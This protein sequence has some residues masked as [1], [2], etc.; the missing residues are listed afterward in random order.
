MN[1]S[2]VSGVT[3]LDPYPFEEFAPTLSQCYAIV[4]AGYL[5]AKTQLLS[6]SDIRGVNAF[7]NYF[8]MPAIICVS[9]SDAN[10]GDFNWELL[11]GLV[12]GKALVFVLV[13]SLTYCISGNIGI[14][15]LLAI[16]CVHSNDLPVGN[17]L[18]SSLYG[19]YRPHMIKYLFL[20]PALTFAIFL[21]IGN[22]MVAVNR[23]RKPPV[24]PFPSTSF[25]SP[26]NLEKSSLVR[27]FVTTFSG[28]L[29]SPVVIA[30]F[31]GLIM[32]VFF[33]GNVP[34]V[35]HKP[36][37]VVAATI[38]GLALSLLGFSFVRKER[39]FLSSGIILAVVLVAVKMLLT[40]LLM[41]VT[42]KILTPKLKE[43]KVLTDFSLLYGIIS[44]ATIVFQIGQEYRKL[45]PAMSVA[46]ILSSLLCFPLSYL[47][48]RFTIA[49]VNK[50]SYYIPH[51][52]NSLFFI[53]SCSV[54]CD[55]FVWISIAWKKKWCK[56]PFCYV[57]H[58]AF[59]QMLTSCG[60]I[61]W[62]LSS[63]ESWALY[64]QMALYYGGE[65]SGYLWSGTMAVIVTLSN[66]YPELAG[67]GYPILSFTAFF[68]SALITCVMCSL[69]PYNDVQ[70][71]YIV[72]RARTNFAFL[73]LIVTSVLLIVC[74]VLISLCLL[75]HFKNSFRKKSICS[76]RIFCLEN[77]P[78]E[79][80]ICKSAKRSSLENIKDVFTRKKEGELYSKENRS[81]YIK[82]GEEDMENEWTFK[83]Y[84][85]ILLIWLTMTLK[86][87]ANI[88]KL[89]HSQA[90]EIMVP[91]EFLQSSLFVGQGIFIFLTFGIDLRTVGISIVKKW[92]NFRYGKENVLLEASLHDA[93]SE[94]KLFCK[95]FYA[96]Y[97]KHCVRDL[98]KD[99]KWKSAV[100]RKCFWG[101]QL[102]D[103]LIEERICQDD[104]EA[105]DYGQKLLLGGVIRHVT[106]TR[107]FYDA[108]YLYKFVGDTQQTK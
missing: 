87:I 4:L 36:I 43:F 68:L 38:P 29:K 21:P 78:N 76:D 75:I 26:N 19:Y 90:L 28:A 20:M 79:E 74:F 100:Y 88:F 52:Q 47:V 18:V 96:F 8:A 10:F 40:P 45:L 14:A 49:P 34:K 46:L 70:K 97:F 5:A 17:P 98:A 12:V 50:L 101:H 105:E 33:R 62:C 35:L 66:K 23:L 61:M 7:A 41:H 1:I 77:D 25:N 65:I 104:A 37:H 64:C 99:R 39:Y 24:N 95:Q 2:G 63:E 15:G 27:E 44:P 9:L 55:V 73:Q 86:I 57:T 91:L 84:S 48:A 51:L 58:L 92:R 3:E 107:H 16:F 89:V 72:G 13:A 80:S 81:D 67:K 71:V 82:I 85:L 31:S 108:P 60:I 83:L 53:A 59:T 30:T 6:P 22:F 93:T 69:I 11:S 103:W 94:E 106:E 42:V 102:V 56:V 32:N 54:V